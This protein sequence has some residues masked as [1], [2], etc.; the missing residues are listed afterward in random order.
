MLM[1]LSGSWSPLHR[2]LNMHHVKQCEMPLKV[3]IS[4]QWKMF[5]FGLAFPQQFPLPNQP[6]FIF[7]MYFATVF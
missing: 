5:L 3:P 6:P 2:Q 4:N 7:C 1:H